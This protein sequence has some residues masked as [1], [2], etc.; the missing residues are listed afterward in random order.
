[1][2]TN[3]IELTLDLPGRD[4]NLIDIADIK[5]VERRFIQ[6]ETIKNGQRVEETVEKCF[7]LVRDASWP[8]KET[9]NEVKSDIIKIRNA[10]ETI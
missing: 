7:V 10:L 1:M 9:Y 4:K 8:V 5:G 6:V 3:F 2:I